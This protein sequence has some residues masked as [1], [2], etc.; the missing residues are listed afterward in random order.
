MPAPPSVRMWQAIIASAGHGLLVIGALWAIGV[1]LVLGGLGWSLYVVRRIVRDARPLDDP[2]WRTLL[3]EVADRLGL[4]ETPRLVV[5]RETHMPF[6]CGVFTPTIVLPEACST[7]SHD[8]RRAVLLHELA[9]IRRRDLPGHMLGRL[10]CAGY[11]FHPLVWMAAKRLRTESERAC[12]D[13]AVTSGTHA[14]D[15]AEHLLDIV[16]AVRAHATP[17]AALA[18]ARR[19]EFEGRMLAILDPE[20]PHTSPSRRQSTLLI[21]GL[22]L[23]AGLVAAAAPVPRDPAAASLPATEGIKSVPVHAASATTRAAIESAPASHPLVAQPHR[24]SPTHPTTKPSAARIR[25]NASDMGAGAKL[26]RPFATPDPRAR[27]SADSQ[28]PN[29]RPALLAKVLRT[30]SSS[31]L[32]RVA[33]WGL[34][35]YDQSSVAEEALVAAVQH[36]ADTSVREMAAWA[37][38]N[39]DGHHNVVSALA[40]ALHADADEQVRATAA[41]A[42]GQ[43]GGADATDALTGALGDANEDVRVRAAWALGNVEPKQAPQALIGLLRDHD[44]E[45][46]RLAAWALFQI[47]NPST[48][49]AL[50][51]A[52]HAESDK[53]VQVAELRAIAVMGDNAVDV[54]R[55]LLESPDPEIKSMAIRGLA[56]GN[57]TGPWPWP[58]PEPR[59]NP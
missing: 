12:N 28:S 16:T 26:I 10:A 37:L 21:A 29:E 19:K 45:T 48:L 20:L 36:D 33:A 5:A 6:G 34:Q 38:A 23:S 41:W 24:L 35:D 31:E 59:P 9:H 25:T 55:G 1:L 50:E 40:G 2:E 8:R 14:A 46:R 13:L 56:G 47:H 42:L 58:W 52:L 44:P 54:L 18:M 3:V 53:D 32:R 51:T 27:P 22:V 17:V 57:A 49:P 30:E 43:A 15:Y 11:W 7:W 4:N 39:F